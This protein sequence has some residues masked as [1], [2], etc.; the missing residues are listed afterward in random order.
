QAESLD[1]TEVLQTEIQ[2]LIDHID[3]AYAEKLSAMEYIDIDQFEST[4]DLTISDN[5]IIEL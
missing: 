2:V 1:I 3:I 4:Q 5:Q